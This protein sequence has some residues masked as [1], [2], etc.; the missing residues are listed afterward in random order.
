MSY[1]K[2]LTGTYDD[3]ITV[4]KRG[5]HI[6]IYDCYSNEYDENSLYYKNTTEKCKLMAQFNSDKQVQEDTITRKLLYAQAWPTICVLVP[7]GIIF[8]LSGL[9]VYFY[10]ALLSFAVLIVAL[11]TLHLKKL[12]VRKQTPAVVANTVSL[13]EYSEYSEY[14]VE[15]GDED[16]EYK[17]NSDQYR[18]Q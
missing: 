10:V 9:S 4:H 11:Q 2:T 12:Q 13:N 15:Y 6:E 1:T 5:T 18:E 16:S 17:V 14:K 3:N 8:Y 7:L